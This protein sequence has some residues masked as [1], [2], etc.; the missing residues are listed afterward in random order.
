MAESRAHSLEPEV[1][2]E[3]AGRLVL[4]P[5]GRSCPS[6]RFWRV[7]AI[8][9][10]PRLVDVSPVFTRHLLCVRAQVTPFHKDQEYWLWGHSNDLTQTWSA[11]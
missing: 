10:A 5:R 8:S 3:G 4:G 1:H 7:L 6:P 2:G 9:G 11:L